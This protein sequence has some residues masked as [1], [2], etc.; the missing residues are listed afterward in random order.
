MIS[1]PEPLNLL[2]DAKRFLGD[3]FLDD[4]EALKWFR[5]NKRGSVV[6]YCRNQE[7]LSGAYASIV[8]GCRLPLLLQLV[9]SRT[10]PRHPPLTWRIMSEAHIHGVME[11]EAVSRLQARVIELV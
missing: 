5:E 6:G 10:A 2:D 9:D 3:N 7:D 8:T 4:S 1:L 11:G